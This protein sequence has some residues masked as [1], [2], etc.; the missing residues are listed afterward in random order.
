MIQI[1][2]A[3]WHLVWIQDLFFKE[4][5]K[6]GKNEVNDDISCNIYKENEGVKGSSYD[7]FWITLTLLLYQRPQ[8]Q[9]EKMSS[10]RGF[11]GNRFSWQS[12]FNCCSFFSIFFD[13]GLERERMKESSLQLI[14]NRI[15]VISFIYVRLDFVYYIAYV[16]VAIF[17]DF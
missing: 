16:H 17:Y 2:F 7:I 12:L 3:C 10:V 9:V 11:M 1:Q 14:S 15:L 6:E 8:M 13:Y 5:E 4:E